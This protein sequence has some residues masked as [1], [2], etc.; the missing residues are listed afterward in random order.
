MQKEKMQKKAEEQ[1]HVE[2]WKSFLVA[3]FVLEAKNW[4]T[5]D[6]SKA[7]K[8]RKEHSLSHSNKKLNLRR[9]KIFSQFL[10]VWDTKVISHEICTNNNFFDDQIFLNI[11]LLFLNPQKY[12]FKY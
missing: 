5:V 1:F 10:G 3:Q 8:G 2:G 6:F 12:L 4:K 11:N 7:E 9:S